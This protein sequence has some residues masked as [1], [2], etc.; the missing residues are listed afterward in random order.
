MLKFEVIIKEMKS[1]SLPNEMIL[2]WLLEN[3]DKTFIFFDTETTGFD[4]SEVDQ[5]TQIAAIAVQLNGDNLRFFEIDTFNVKVKLNDALVKK[6][7]TEPDEPENDEE[8]KTWMFGTK[9]GILKYNHYDFVNSSKFVDERTALEQFDKFLKS[10]DDVILFAHNAPFD[11]KWVQF[12]ELF[13]NSAYKVYDTIDFF[14]NTFFPTITKL[15]CEVPG[16][17]KPA[18][19]KFP[20]A[21]SKDGS[22]KPSAGLVNLC[23]GFNN[24][25]NNL[26]AKSEG[27]H[28]AIVDCQNTVEVFQEGL[29]LIREKL[30]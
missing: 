30:R 3:I 14:K 22:H 23:K 29:N 9:K 28:D 20:T 5:I 16:S 8:K 6:M 11:M 27:A 18:L 24:S 21:K 26:L 15:A 19:D 2:K 13:K 25:M 4:R 12:H 7:E 10:H 17:Y 1:Q